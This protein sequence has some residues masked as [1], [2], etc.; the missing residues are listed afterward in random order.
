[1]EAHFFRG[2]IESEGIGV[3][4]VGEALGQ[5]AGGVP[6]T[7]T[8]PEIWVDA[9]SAERALKVLAE[10]RAGHWARTGGEWVC[11]NCG[12]AI[13]AQFTDCWKCQTPR[14]LTKVEAA[15]KS[16]DEPFVAADVACRGCGYN[17]RGLPATGRCPECGRPILRTLAARWRGADEAERRATREVMRYVAGRI[18][19]PL[20]AVLF[21]IS[22]FDAMVGRIGLDPAAVDLRV[23]DVRMFCA[24]IGYEAAHHFGTAEHAKEV[25]QAWGVTTSTDLGRI[26]SVLWDDG[27][28]DDPG[29]PFATLV[30]FDQWF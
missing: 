25:L 27:R 18:G 7:S 19:Y 14:P 29:G 8:L 5:V 15:P 20:E 30:P 16:L 21:L 10:A 28:P 17:L 24:A 1:M 11:P 6:V 13:E 2:L 26:L 23:I 3:R 12:E 9:A 22:A 4:I